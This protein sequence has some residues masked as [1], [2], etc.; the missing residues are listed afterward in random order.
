[1]SETAAKNETL[2]S[3][4]LDSEI[5][6]SVIVPV[7]NLEICVHSTLESLLRIDPDGPCE[8][9]AV[10]DGSTDGSLAVL[11]KYE[12]KNPRIRVIAKKNSGVSETRNAGIEAAKGKYL[13]FCDGD[14]T[15]EPAFFRAAVDEMER[16]GFDLVQGN[17]LFVDAYTV[18][19]ILPG[20]PRRESADPEEILEWFFG[21][22]ETL[23][24]SACA[25]V[26]RREVIGN[27]RFTP[28][29]R[30]AEDQLFMFGVLQNRPKVLILDADAYR[31]CARVSSVMHSG[32]AE[33]GWDA[34]RVLEECGKAVESPVIRRHIEKRKTDVLVRIYNTAKAA[35]K[36]TGRVLEEIRKVDVPA[37]REDL[38]KKEYGKLVLLQNFRA[39]YDILLK[40][41]K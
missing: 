27:V 7:H 25:K 13:A 16:N 14:D 24:F 28:G 19:K 12:A 3:E 11:R 37:I 2:H 29:I 22:E 10:D 6:L 36:D 30:V 4:A 41:A 26:F 39:V 33:K 31:Y 15:V 34:L 38:T 35:G 32:Y 18:E 17:I 1:M 40:A 21:R 5:L 20:S 8:I 23:L 9:I